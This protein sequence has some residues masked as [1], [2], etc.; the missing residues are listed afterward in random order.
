MEA[1]GEARG[2]GGGGRRGRSGGGCDMIYN[3][4]HN[5]VSDINTGCGTRHLSHAA[6][7]LYL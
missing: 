2:G 5:G 4:K 3:E 6:Q 1:G 7:S